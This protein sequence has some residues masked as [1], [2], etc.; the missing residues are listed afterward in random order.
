MT[1][2]VVVVPPVGGGAGAWATGQPAP[3]GSVAKAPANP[4]FMCV[5]RE[6]RNRMGPIRSQRVDRSQSAGG[7]ESDAC[8]GTV[9]A[10]YRHDRAKLMNLVGELC[11]RGIVKG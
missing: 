7:N 1:G 9:G 10:T 3:S 4:N 8:N 5:P 6:P 11:E 2:R